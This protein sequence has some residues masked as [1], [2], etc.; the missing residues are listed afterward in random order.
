MADRS[1][2]SPTRRLEACGLGRDPRQEAVLGVGVPRHV[3]L[4]QAVG[5]PVDRGQRGTKLMAEP[6]QEVALQLLRAAQR[7]GFPV[8]ALGASRVRGPAAASG[9]RPRAARPR[10]RPAR[11]P[12]VDRAIGQAASR[13]SGPSGAGTRAART[14]DPAASIEMTGRVAGASWAACKRG[15]SSGEVARRLPPRRARPAAPPRLL[16]G[17]PAEQA[18]SSAPR[19]SRRVS[20]ATSRPSESGTDTASCSS[21][22]RIVSSTRLRAVT[23]PSRPSR[24][25]VLAA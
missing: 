8:G 11:C 21:T 23:S 15:R 12:A 10:R 3:G 25:A 17:H 13:V 5:V 22:T 14:R 2:R 20:I 4:Q 24:S 18:T 6:G 16:V 9:R 1:S 19:P 7:R